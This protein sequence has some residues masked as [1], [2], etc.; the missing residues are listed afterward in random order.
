MKRILIKNTNLISMDE[1]RNKIE[2]NVDILIEDDKIIDIANNI[3]SDALVIDGTGK[4]VLPGLVNAHCHIPMSIFKETVDGYPLK[5]WLEQSIWPREAKLTNDDV[6]YA[7]LL[8]FIEMIKTGTTTVNDHYFFQDEIIRA[9]Q[10]AG[11]HLIETRVVMDS[12]NNGNDRYQELLTF[13][14]KYKS[15]NYLDLSIGIHGLYTNSEEYVK[16]VCS[17]AREKNLLVHMH[18]CE[19]A[20]EVAT[21]KHN[22]RV[23]HPAEVLQ[24]YF[25]DLKIVLAHGVKLD[26]NDIQIMKDMNVGI[27]HCPVTNLKLGSGIADIAK[28]KD[29]NI[30]VALG[31]DGPGSGSN[32]DMFEVMKFAALLQKGT[33]EEPLLMP[34]Y[35]VLK[36]ATIE[37][38]KVLGLSHKIGSIEVGKQAN[39]IVVSL[40]NI[41]TQPVNDVIADIVYNANQNNIEHVMVNG[42]L[43]LKNH[44]LCQLDEKEIIE[45]CNAITKRIFN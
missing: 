7:S 18:F 32:F 27:A 44:H 14:D 23:N 24:N 42:N 36:M 41:K 39:L 3:N 10:K 15:N 22:Y 4:Y 17:L 35:D 37:G 2:N 38:A 8:S 12:D 25:S 34:A 11:I 1:K 45:K 5:E 31:T 13:L 33:H 29:N 21:I 43:I 30:P 28:L 40:D 19:D 9:G 26:D 16:K 20:N 6:Y